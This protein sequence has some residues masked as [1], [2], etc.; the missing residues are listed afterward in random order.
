MYLAM[1]YG[2]AALS[3]CWSA[4]SASPLCLSAPPPLAVPSLR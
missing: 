2:V 4:A 3:A 1:T